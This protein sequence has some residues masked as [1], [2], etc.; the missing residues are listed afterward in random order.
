MKDIDINN[1]PKEKFVL[2]ENRDLH[3]VKFDTK[4]IGYFHDAWIRFRKNK[5]SVTAAVIILCIVLFAIFAPLISPYDVSYSETGYSNKVPKDKFLSNFGIATG[6]TERKL[7][8]NGYAKEIGIGI[9][10]ADT[11]GTG[12][13]WAEGL[14]N[15]FCPVKS[16]GEVYITEE[17]EYRN[18]KVDVYLE[19][20]FRYFTVTDE[21]LADI[22]AW[23]QETGKQ[24]IYPMVDTRS[25]Y[26]FDANDAN[27]WYKTRPGSLAP[28]RTVI[29][30]TASINLSEIDT[31]T[32]VLEDNYLRDEKGNVLFKRG[33]GQTMWKI[34][35]LY[36][37]YYQYKHGFEPYHIFGTDGSG[38]DIC[39]RL[40]DGIRLSLLIAVAVS[41]INFTI[42]TIYGAIEGYFG[43]WVDIVLERV[44]DIL[45]GV[46]F[47]V[48]ATL[49]QLYYSA[50]AGPV[51]SLL[52]AF[53][54]TG[55]LGTAYR[56]RTQFYRFKN[57]EYVFA[58]RTLGASNKRLMFKHI[59]PNSLGT[60]ITSSVL[61]I[62]GVIFSEAMLSYLGI[63]MLQGDSGTSLGTMLANAQGVFTQYPHEMLFPAL[64]ISLLMISFNLFGNGLR[65][66]FNPSLRGVED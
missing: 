27:C 43:G 1:I 14:N 54:L 65:D 56:V 44:S 30:G 11:D 18:A 6:Q 60:I 62:P 39:V 31:D 24:V 16:E 59:F 40:A 8:N 50:K 5:A 19:E 47:I 22:Q 33:I 26:C 32:M 21:Q 41:L 38:Y 55:W 36:Y 7:N 29:G 45:S 15:E 49:F 52:F 42:G 66:A 64:V 20:G 51:V 57:S 58:A 17:K 53:V 12:A 35:V 28:V 10:A 3:D 4:P 2:L 46:P 63:V 13:T 61:V 25:E 48:V 34:R 23:E 37:N 9:A